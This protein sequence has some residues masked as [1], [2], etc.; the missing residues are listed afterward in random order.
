MSYYVIS[1]IIQ[2]YYWNSFFYN[3]FFFMIFTYII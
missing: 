2:L 3:I 1:I